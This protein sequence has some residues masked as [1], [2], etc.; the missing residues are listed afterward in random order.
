MARGSSRFRQRGGSV[1][2]RHDRGDG[3]VGGSRFH[4]RHDQHRGRGCCRQRR[5]RLLHGSQNHF[6]IRLLLRVTAISLP[7][8]NETE[9][10]SHFPIRTPILYGEKNTPCLTHYNL[11]LFFTSRLANPPGNRA[12]AYFIYVA[13]C[14]V[15][16]YFIYKFS[17]NEK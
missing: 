10:S 1:I 2:P 7:T 9:S 12:V 14:V 15:C 17:R 11:T 5:R 6:P 13:P 3:E 16:V 8:G 4:R